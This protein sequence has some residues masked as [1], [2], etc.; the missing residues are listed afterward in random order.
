M[1]S[2]QPKTV[3]TLAMAGTCP[4]HSRTDVSIRDLVLSLDEPLERGGTNVGP[5]PTETMIG[6]LVACTNVVGH[7]VAE[8]AGIAI[9]E[10]TIKAEAQFDRRGVTMQDEVQVPFPEIIL[11]IDLTADADDAAV[12]ALRDGLAKYC[13]VSRVLRAAGSKLVTN[14]NVTW[15]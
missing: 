1:V 9:R 12:E 5:S 2:V 6:A 8:S 14:W 7:R 4:S 13:P 3:V 15:P 11:S 10:M